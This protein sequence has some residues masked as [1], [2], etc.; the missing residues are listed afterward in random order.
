MKIISRTLAGLA[1][2][3]L[4]SAAPLGAALAQD[5]DANAVLARLKAEMA[6]QGTAIDWAKAGTSKNDEGDEVIT[7]SGVTVTAGT[8]T[9]PL[10]T[11][12][13]LTGITQ[14]DDGGYTIDELYMPSYLYQDNDSVVSLSDISLDGVQ[15]PAEGADDSG[16]LAGIMMYSGAD[17]GSMIV[18]VKGKQV[19][20]MQNLSFDITPPDNSQPM[21]F[22]GGANSFSV[23]LDKMKDDQNRAVAQAMGY[24][25]ITGNFQLAGSWTPQDG[26]VKLDKYDLTVDDA[27]TI[28]ISLE[29]AGYTPEFIKQLRQ[30]QAQIAANPGQGNTALGFAVMGMMQQL[31]FDNAKIYFLDDKLTKKVLQFVAGQQGAQAKDIANQAKAMVPFMMMSL[32]DPE[33]TK[34]AATAVSQFLDDPKNIAVAAE[35]DKPIPFSMIMAG[36]MSAPQSL[37]KQLGVK[38]RANQ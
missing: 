7:L 35:P 5:V 27:G 10:Q 16:P 1:V 23:D 29:I 11:D 13:Q 37:P 22:S 18:T 19:F 14:G 17:L 32:N 26:R 25:Q 36:A 8:N 9:V 20:T 6:K 30:M 4:L 24:S 38:I 28:G 15:I 2:S 12:V 21:E 34:M 31:T 33:L 3:G